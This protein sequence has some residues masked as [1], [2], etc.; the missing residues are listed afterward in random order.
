MGLMAVFAGAVSS[1]HVLARDL[2]GDIHPMQVAFFR[3]IVP[4]IILTP[5]LMRQGR[6]WWKT[7]RPGLQFLRGIVGGTSMLTWF[8]ALSL[9]P[10]AE[11]TALSFTVVIFA[12]LGAALFLN[13]QLGKHRWTAIIVG[14]IGTFIILR[15]NNS[16]LNPGVLVALI[17]SFFWALALL[18]VKVLSRTDTP[19]TIVFYSSVY[20]TLLASIPAAYY[21]ANPSIA[22]LG[23]LICVGILTTIAQLCVTEALKVAETTAIMPIDFTRLIWA[24]A[25]GYIWFGEFPDFWTW[26]GG[27]IVF[28]STLYIIYRESR[29]ASNVPNKS[30][31][32]D[33][34]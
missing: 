2:S 7:T 13:E 22:Q 31:A 8:Y 5:I 4:L 6:R 30:I 23:L 21:W 14:I 26:I 9:I 16:S 28:T 17:S 18:S 25:L 33:F 32:N 29:P 20:F 19:L 27:T 11:A 12:S 10:V 1:S 3:T 15:P 24:A 34:T